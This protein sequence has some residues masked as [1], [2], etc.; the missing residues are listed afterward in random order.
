MARPTRAYVLITLDVEP[1]DAEKL[2]AVVE[3]V[4]NAALTAA[5]D[6]AKEEGIDVTPSA[7]AD[8]RADAPPVRFTLDLSAAK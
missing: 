1:A 2:D 6:H 3:G 8:A 7:Y 5:L 4:K